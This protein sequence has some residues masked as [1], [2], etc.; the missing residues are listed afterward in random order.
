M[1]LDQSLQPDPTLKDIP[2]VLPA[3]Y[4]NDAWAQPGGFS[5]N[6]PYHLEA[7]GPLRVLWA[8]EAGKGSDNASRLTAPPIVAGGLVF[9]LDS[10]ARVFA[11]DAKSGA[12][13]WHLEL[14]PK[15][16]Q[17]FVNEF[18]L[19]VVGP[20]HGIDP[21]KGFGGGL[22][23]DDGKVFVSTGFGDVFCAQRRERKASLED[24]AAGAHRQRA[25]GLVRTRLRLHRGQ[26]FLRAGAD[27]RP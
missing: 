4:R 2:V 23:F 24:A 16:Q 6:A 27:G 17:S 20:N 8:Q 22:A 13:R 26:S 19:G 11:F 5:T 10:Q 14:A 7:S 18:S 15:G 1:S 12:P 21:S 3:P 25:R 9:V